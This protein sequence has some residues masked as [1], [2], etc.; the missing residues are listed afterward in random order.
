MPDAPPPRRSSPLR[1]PEGKQRQFRRRLR[2]YRQGRPRRPIPRAAV[3]SFFTLMNLFSGFLAIT[4]T[5]EGNFVQACW[6]IVLAG[7]F[8]ALDGM[9]ARLTN[10]QSL[11]GVELDSLADVV[12]FGTAPAVLVYV[13]GLQDFGV[14]GLIVASLPAICGAVRLARFNVSFDGEKKDYFTGLPIPGQ[15]VAIVALILNFQDPNVFLSEDNLTLLMPLV[16]VL[17]ALMISN[18][19][20]EAIPKP[21]VGYLRAHPR[22]SLAFGVMLVLTFVWIPAGLLVSLTAYLV[23]GIVR[24]LVRVV[25]QVMETP[26]EEEG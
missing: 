11:F 14:L 19:R 22:K 8:D 21:S 2:A 3:P 9:M 10:G 26:I 1:R 7:F 4:Q 12:S 18:I 13:F 25:Q 6:L 16:F 15:A 17:S 23:Y 5:L 20:F 24:A